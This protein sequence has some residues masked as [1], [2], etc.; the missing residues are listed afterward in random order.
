M[1]GHKEIQFSKEQVDKA[2]CRL[3]FQFFVVDELT[4]DTEPY[5]AFMATELLEHLEVRL[6]FLQKRHAQLLATARAM[7][8]TS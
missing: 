2:E 5:Y 8:P 3:N 4:V 6:T 7:A 1:I